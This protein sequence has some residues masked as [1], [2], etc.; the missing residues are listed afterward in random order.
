M[1]N[2]PSWWISIKW[3]AQFFLHHFTVDWAEWVRI[4]INS[5][6]WPTLNDNVF[7]FVSIP[8]KTNG[9][10]TCPYG[11]FTMSDFICS[12]LRGC[13]KSI[14]YVFLYLNFCLQFLV[15][16]ST[17]KWFL[18]MWN[19]EYWKFSPIGNKI[20]SCPPMSS[21]SLPISYWL[22]GLVDKFVAWLF[23]QQ[24]IDHVQQQSPFI[25]Q[26]HHICSIVKMKNYGK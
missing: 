20:S 12:E 5:K 13:S 19:K 6:F 3:N 2:A 24:P 1:N 11:R 15:P 26:L 22:F 18:H 8:Y 4:L 21:W 17:A 7:L 14:H 9:I 10:S 23:Q 25:H 16:F